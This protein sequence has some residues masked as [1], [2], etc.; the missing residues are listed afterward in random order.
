[1]SLRYSKSPEVDRRP[2][3]WW[4]GSVR[5]GRLVRNWIPDGFDRYARVLHP[6]DRDGEFRLVRWEELSRWSGQALHATSSIHEL[7]HPP[8]GSAWEALGNLP[9]EG[10]LDPVML[11]RLIQLL[12]QHTTTPQSVW[13]LV[14]RGYDADNMD[15]KR[16][17]E[18]HPSWKGA[19][20]PY[21]LYGGGHRR[22]YVHA[23]DGTATE[24]LVA[25]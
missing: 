1:M 15:A 7:T 6:A 8:D 14:W 2:L 25:R 21:L 11:D 3:D 23:N 20:R 19:G 16:A 10:Q 24:L 22:S 17:F 12:L 5:S 18:I 4:T 9:Q 13:F